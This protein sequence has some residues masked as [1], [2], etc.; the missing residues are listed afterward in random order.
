M[1]I[2]LDIGGANIKLA[3]ENG[4]AYSFPFP[5]WKKPLELRSALWDALAKFPSSTAIAVVMT[6]E[7]ADCFMDRG[8]GVKHI[9]TECIGAAH[10]LGIEHCFFYG[11]DGRFRRK[12]ELESD[13]DQLASANWHALATYV[14][15]F[16]QPDGL[17]I[18]IGSTTTDII[19][20]VGAKVATNARSDYERLR[21]GSLVY[22]GCSRT[23]VCALCQTLPFRG[24][25]I[26]VMKEVFATI[27][28]ARLVLGLTPEEPDDRNTADNTP[29]MI[30]NSVNRLG[31]MIGLDH[32]HVTLEDASQIALT[33]LAAARRIIENSIEKLQRA[34]SAKNFVLSGHGHDLHSVVD[35]L[36]AK[37]VISLRDH[38]GEDISRA[39]PSFAVAKL[40]RE[41]S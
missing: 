12:L 27:D 38:L 23:P 15:R 30:A 29:R 1:I 36:S 32:R 9:A 22:V 37:S 11:T 14:A 18:D 2:G 13:V 3:S 34:D 40:L 17:L 33:V 10:N 7:M 21:E 6:G 19:P 8:D 31:R 4:D 28:D 16:V 26:P 24:N 39:A 41:I 5:L 25:R 35:S 20:I